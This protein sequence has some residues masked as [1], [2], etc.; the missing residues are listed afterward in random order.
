MWYRSEE[1]TGHGSHEGSDGEGHGKDGSRFRT[2]TQRLAVFTVGEFG[3]RARGCA[4]LDQN[5]SQ[6]FWKISAARK[7]AV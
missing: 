5:Q 4:F 2:D 3:L 7:D 1:L 6:S